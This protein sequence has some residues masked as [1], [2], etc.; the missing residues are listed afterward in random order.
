MQGLDLDTYTFVGDV[1]LSLRVVPLTS[2]VGLFLTLL[3]A[4]GPPSP[5]WT[6]YLA[7]SPERIC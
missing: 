7:G 2:R 6:D 5:S 1:Q 3:P 4:I